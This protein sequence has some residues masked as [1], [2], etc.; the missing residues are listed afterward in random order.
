M[1]GLQGCMLDLQGCML[2][3]GFET[4]VHVVRSTVLDCTLGLMGYTLDCVGFQTHF[5]VVRP[6]V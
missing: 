6:I 5:H 4:L 1:L 2:D 3:F